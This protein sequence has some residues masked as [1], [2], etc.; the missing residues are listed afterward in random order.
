[1]ADVGVDES[2]LK[3]VAERVAGEAAELVRDAWEGMNRGRVVRVDTKSADTDVVTAVDHESEQLVRARLA[4]LRPGDAVLGEEG[5]GDAGDGVTWVVDPID[6]TVN[7]LYGLPWFAVSVAAQVDGVSV[8][9]AVV[10]PVS[11]RVWT[12]ARGQGAWL[13]GRPLTTS[14]PERLDLTLVGTGFAYKV[15]RRLR[16]ARFAAGLVG[17]VR[18]IRRNGAASLDLC[19]VG[20][21]WLDAYVE[22]GLGR[23]DWAA[24]ALVASE[25]GA[26]VSLPGEDPALGP[27][28]TYAA[29]S[30][31]ATPLRE[32]LI[33]SGIGDV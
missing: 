2:L 8:A 10:E 33:A 4:E 19:A 12:A 20:A 9:G 29:A 14:A 1:M 24:G 27:D 30:S 16:Q 17:R 26:T 31:I 13:D 3:G 18:D 32:A 7:F 28:A 25:A 22:H 21:G 23:W 15:D 11:G 6:G 5:G